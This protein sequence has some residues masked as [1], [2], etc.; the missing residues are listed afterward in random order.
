VAIYAGGRLPGADSDEIADLL[1]ATAVLSDRLYKNLR[2]RQ[3]LAY[4]TGASTGVDRQV[5]WYMLYIAT[6]GENFETAL[7]GLILQTDKLSFDG[8]TTNEV[9]RAANDIWGRMLRVKTA[10]LNQAFYMA[11]DEF[12]GRPAGN[13]SARLDRLK[14]ADRL[15]VRRVAA[16]YFRPSLWIVAAAGQVPE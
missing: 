4:S 12:L 16:R 3:G 2:E 1:V 11:Q 6:G 15:S 13:D 5:G 7:D 14:T 10:R 9:K 8:P